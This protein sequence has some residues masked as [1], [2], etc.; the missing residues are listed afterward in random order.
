MWQKR[1][2]LSACAAR[3]AYA[4]LLKVCLRVV[5]YI[6]Q[7]HNKPQHAAF[8]FIA[9]DWLLFEGRLCG[10]L[11]SGFKPNLSCSDVSS[12]HCDGAKGITSCGGCH[13]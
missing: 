10:K 5:Q 12:A 3:A 1:P 6:L 13:I 9:V 11:I 8:T 7:L 2:T 4:Q